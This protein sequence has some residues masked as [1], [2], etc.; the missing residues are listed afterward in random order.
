MKNWKALTTPPSSL[1]DTAKQP[2]CMHLTVNTRVHTL[3][4]TM[5]N[6]CTIGTLGCPL[7]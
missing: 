5:Y 6:I 7:F 3:R 2:T 1:L 4:T